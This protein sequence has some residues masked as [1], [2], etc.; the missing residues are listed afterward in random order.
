[1]P[2][3]SHGKMFL[4]KASFL[5]HVN[6]SP[7]FGNEP[8]FSMPLSTGDMADAALQKKK[9]RELVLSEVEY[10]RQEVERL[11]TELAERG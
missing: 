6:D 10:Y 1:M 11:K 2:E 5:K 4:I 8:A 7:L 9:E 3:G